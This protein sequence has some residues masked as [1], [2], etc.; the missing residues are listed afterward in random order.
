LE[1]SFTMHGGTTLGRWR[2]Q[3]RLA[4]ALELLAA[5]TSVTRTGTI[6]G[7]ATTSAFIDAF[8][9]EFGATPSRYFAS[10]R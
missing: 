1:R 9:H 5:G 7:Y 4:R 2:Q 8:R 6:V 10:V 3:V